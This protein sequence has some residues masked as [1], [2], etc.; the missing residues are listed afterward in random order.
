[1][2]NGFCIGFWLDKAASSENPDQK[3]NFYV[4]R[5]NGARSTQGTFANTQI[6]CLNSGDRVFAGGKDDESKDEILTEN[7][8]IKVE[9]QPDYHL[10]IKVKRIG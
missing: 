4:G 2:V 3:T 9:V 10:Y 7:E 8:T 5:K 6:R 1:M